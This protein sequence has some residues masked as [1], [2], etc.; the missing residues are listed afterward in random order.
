MIKFEDFEKILKH[1]N[2]LE[3][4]NNTKEKQTFDIAKNYFKN[5]KTDCT[6]NKNLIRIIGQSGSGKTTQLLPASKVFC[7]KKEIRSI[8]FAVRNFAHLHPDYQKLLNDFGKSEIRE[9]TNCFALKCL[10]INLIMAIKEGCDII[11][12]VTFLT[13]EFEDFVNSYLKKYGYQCLYLCCA[14]SKNISD[15]FIKKRKNSKISKEQ[16]RVVY[17]SSSNFFYKNLIEMMKYYSLN[18]SKEKI[19]IWNAFDKK[20]VFYGNFG[21]SYAIFDREIKNSSIDFQNEKE[22]LDEKIKFLC[23]LN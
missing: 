5:L 20:P 9:K 16:S 2:G 14:V 3:W 19:V 1:I 4:E 13:K 21:E 23:E 17:K 15:T 10:L 11:F 22:L 18:F 12:E 6:K 8:N 7:D